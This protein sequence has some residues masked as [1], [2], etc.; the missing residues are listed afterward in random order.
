MTVTPA[1]EP[2]KTAQI[3]GHLFADRDVVVQA[4]VGPWLKVNAY[5]TPDP[6][7]DPTLTPNHDTVLPHTWTL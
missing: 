4:E 2:I 1:A 3:V 5:P 6:E 7:P